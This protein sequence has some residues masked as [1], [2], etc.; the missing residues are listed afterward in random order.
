[1]FGRGGKPNNGLEVCLGVLLVTSSLLLGW[2]T[3]KAKRVEPY[4]DFF[5]TRLQLFMKL[6]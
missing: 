1:M 5:E 2:L 4:S 6:G 3:L